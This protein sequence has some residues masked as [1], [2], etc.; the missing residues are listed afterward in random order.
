MK[1]AVLVA[2]TLVS[3][4]AGAAGE[5]RIGNVASLHG[6][7]IRFVNTDDGVVAEKRVAATQ[8]LAAD[9][10][11]LALAGFLNTARILAAL[12]TMKDSTSATSW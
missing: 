3:T 4:L 2:L 9:P 5:V 6:R 8:E 1:V 7:A 10:Q 11:I 12:N